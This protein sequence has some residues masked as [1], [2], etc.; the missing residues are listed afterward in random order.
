[1]HSD[2]YAGSQFGRGGTGAFADD[3]RDLFT[4]TV[5]VTI[6]EAREALRTPR[7]NDDET[8][9]DTP[10]ISIRWRS[11]PRIL[12]AEWKGFA[13]SAEFRTALLTGV[14]AIR[15]HHVVG[16]V[17]DARKARVVVPEDERWGRE[18]WLPQAVAAGLK[19]M[20]VVTPSAGLGKMAYDDAATAMDSHGLSMRTFD[21]VAT[22]TTWAL[23]GLV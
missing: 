2:G 6:D 22:A 12:Y 23:T 4:Y 8:Y 9:I 17:S 13:T 1:M 3:T 18:V 5:T 10:Y 19:R 14:R 20:A 15:E 21:S 16:Y 7:P 11:V